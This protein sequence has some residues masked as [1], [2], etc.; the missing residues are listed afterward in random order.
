M[1]IISEIEKI[2]AIGKEP[3]NDFE[4]SDIHHRS[5]GPFST[6]SDL[7]DGHANWFS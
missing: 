2:M 1:Q 6:V 4:V 3:S 5:N 7:L